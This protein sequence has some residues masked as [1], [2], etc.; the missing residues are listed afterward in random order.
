MTMP[1][2]HARVA[3]ALLI[4][5]CWTQLM[6]CED[7]DDQPAPWLADS[8][9]DNPLPTQMASEY[10]T[11]RS[12]WGRVRF[13]RMSMQHGSKNQPVALEIAE[14]V[15]RYHEHWLNRDEAAMATLLHRDIVRAR[16]GFV[17]R[18]RAETLA[19]AAT[20]MW[21]SQSTRPRMYSPILR[22]R[23]RGFR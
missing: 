22:V 14:L 7:P 5:L 13:D 8:I 1:M 20:A 16:N 15:K 19:A 11:D 4:C 17:T 3:A 21:T 2:M 10:V 23:V 12:R 6:A 9:L 18:G